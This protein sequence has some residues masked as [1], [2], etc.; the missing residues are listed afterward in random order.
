MPSPLQ[1]EK[2]LAAKVWRLGSLK[3]EAFMHSL[4]GTSRQSA[5]RRV[6]RNHAGDQ[7]WPTQST[8]E[9]GGGGGPTFSSVHILPEHREW[10]GLN[11]RSTSCSGTG[12]PG[13]GTGKQLYPTIMV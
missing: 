13:S 7:S 2:S 11:G 1:V 6:H 4:R 8:L 9:T 10:G 3:A 12:L 5:P